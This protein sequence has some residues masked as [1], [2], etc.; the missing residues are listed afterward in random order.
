MKQVK[1]FLFSLFF[2]CTSCLY[3]QSF[4]VRKRNVQR[5]NY[6][7]NA[8]DDVLSELEHKE[9]LLRAEMEEMQ[10]FLM[11]ILASNI[12]SDLRN[13]M[14]IEYK[15]LKSMILKLDTEF[16]SYSLN[17]EFNTLKQ[18]VRQNIVDHNNKIARQ[19]EEQKYKNQT[20]TGFA[21]NNGYIVTN[22]HVVDGASSI[23]VQGI[24]GD[25]SKQYN[26]TIVAV[27]KNNDLALLQ[28]V[29]TDFE[30]FGVIP[31]N[32]MSTVSEVGEDIFVL[33]YPLTSTMGDEI[34]LT[35]G[36]IS[37]KTGFQG[38]VSLYQ[39][40][41]PVQ[42]G[43]SGG[44]LFDYNGN[45]IGIISAKHNGAENVG[46]AIKASYLK[47]LIESSVSTPI[48]PNNNKTKDLPLTG[49]VKTMKDFVYMISCSNHK[50][51]ILESNN[52][53]ITASLSEQEDTDCDVYVEYPAIEFTP[54][55]GLKIK[56]VKITK[57][58]TAIE[59]VSSNKVGKTYYD[60]CNID[61]N[62]YI[63][64]DGEK[65]SLTRTEGI[66]IAPQKTCFSYKGEEITFTLYFP[67]IPQN[68]TS[69]TLIESPES[70]W[71]FYGIKIQ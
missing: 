30:G 36:V 58:Y 50:D 49:K 6:E 61:K 18:R 1:T 37:S 40:S 56:S 14:N 7:L 5:S 3:A 35:T 54:A 23:S 34:K 62:T 68:T 48:L 39:I 13:L 20:G 52:S 71:N 25:F 4:T 69:I 60:W 29:D 21:I 2:I 45:L 53:N 12:D 17:S 42:P 38:D 44:P 31:Y 19:S 10:N 43:N 16:F 67:S 9:M 70:T 63:Y 57:D 65:Y 15:E 32:V 28:I 59:I 26:V 22:Y 51:T 47:N 33:G 64:T 8:L 24:N 66:K 27:D 41:A 55:E 46:Y 11:E